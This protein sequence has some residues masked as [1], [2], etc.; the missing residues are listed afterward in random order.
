MLISDLIKNWSKFSGRASRLEFFI[1]SLMGIL[2]LILTFFL[3]VKVFE[4]FFGDYQNAFHQQV[5]SAEYANAV[6][7]SAFREWLDTGSIDQTNNAVKSYYQ[8]YENNTIQQI[9]LSSLSFIFFLPFAIAW[10]AG[11]VRRLHDIGTFG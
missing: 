10:I 9:F 5:S 3:A 11:A 7:N 2:A 1:I 6:L 8:D 4:L